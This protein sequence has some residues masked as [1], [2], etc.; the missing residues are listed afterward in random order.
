MEVSLGCCGVWSCLLDWSTATLSVEMM[1]LG[2]L[3]TVP[4]PFCFASEDMFHLFILRILQ[5][6]AEIFGTR[7]LF[8]VVGIFTPLT[9]SSKGCS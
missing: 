5:F 2:H 7:K 8:K 1:P 9:A 3:Y 4:C 6:L